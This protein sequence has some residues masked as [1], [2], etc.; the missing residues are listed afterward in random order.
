[1]Q[2]QGVGV[3]L[4][5]P[6]VCP[7]AWPGLQLGSQSTIRYT[8]FERDDN[9]PVVSCAISRRLHWEIENPFITMAYTRLMSPRDWVPHTNPCFHYNHW[10]PTWLRSLLSKEVFTWENSHRHKFHT[11]MTFWFRIVF[12]WRRAVKMFLKEL[13]HEIQPN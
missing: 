2:Q 10:T 11:G 5:N 9:G 6:G 12:T 3:V 4:G 1:M 7:K 13:C 8:S